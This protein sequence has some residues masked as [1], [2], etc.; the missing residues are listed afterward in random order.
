MTC[1]VGWGSSFLRHMKFLEKDLESIIWENHEAC[2]GRGLAIDNSFFSKGLRFRQMELGPFG[3]ADLVYV[4]FNPELAQC[5]VQVVE[6]KRIVVN[7]D[8]YLQAKRYVAGLRALFDQMEFLGGVGV[9]FTTVLVGQRVNTDGLLAYVISE[10]PGCQT[11]TYRYDVDGIRFN[12]AT[13]HWWATSRG[14]TMEESMNQ[15]HGLEEHMLSAS[16]A[17]C[18]NRQNNGNERM[19]IVISSHGVIVNPLLLA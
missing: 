13:R 19:P 1:V 15:G 8:S 7:A 5:W 9:S 12:N 6:C 18:Q 10:D 4:R 11:F 16:Y 17:H 3:T 2:E 14:T